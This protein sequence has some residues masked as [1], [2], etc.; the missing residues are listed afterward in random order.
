MRSRLPKVLHR[1]GGRPVLGYVIDVARETTGRRPL[2]VYSPATVQLRE[3]FGDEADF[4]LQD[5]PRGTGDA[6]RAALGSLPADAGEVLVLSGDTPLLRSGTIGALVEQRRTRASP[7]ALATFRPE[8]PRLY[9]RVV[10]NGT[11]VLRIVEAKDA[12]ADELAIDEVNGGVYAFDVR[13]LRANVG[14][15][16]TSPATGESY[17]T[18]LVELARNTGAAATAFEVEDEL[19]LLG[20]DDRLQLAVAEAEIRWRTIE[21]HLLAGVT[22]DT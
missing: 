18:G 17:L 7:M 3:V 11:D 4:A 5:K 16:A 21:R 20:V 22:M 15:L 12:S 19:E 9:G 1:I 10:R 2:V 6:L 8:D 13:W 14:D